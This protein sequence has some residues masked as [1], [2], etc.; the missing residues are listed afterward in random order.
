MI[1]GEAP[2]PN[3][4]INEPLLNSCRDEDFQYD[5][6]CIIVS[7]QTKFDYVLP[8]IDTPMLPPTKTGG[9][10][11]VSELEDEGIKEKPVEIPIE[12]FTKKDNKANDSLKSILQA[13]LGA[14]NDLSL[15]KTRT[16]MDDP[17]VGTPAD[18]DYLEFESHT[19]RLIARR[20]SR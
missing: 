1:R 8:M 20:L 15:R 13:K 19:P 4:S 14:K 5:K 11:K 10:L 9:R 7:S 12:D 6:M 16:V 18:T 17:V 3:T 2:D